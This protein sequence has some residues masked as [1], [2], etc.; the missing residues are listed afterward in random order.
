[1]GLLPRP[2]L[3]I[4]MAQQHERYLGVHVASNIISLSLRFRLKDCANK[5]VCSTCGKNFFVVTW[6]FLRHTVLWLH[7]IKL[8]LSNPARP[9]LL[10]FAPHKRISS[11]RLV[12]SGRAILLGAAVREPVYLCWLA[13]PTTPM[14][15]CPLISPKTQKTTFKKILNVTQPPPAPRPHFWKQRY[16]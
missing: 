7:T 4:R 1:M 11:L 12:S 14:T 10:C 6:W 15:Y 8:L 5:F 9:W 13:R 2:C 16:G 3:I